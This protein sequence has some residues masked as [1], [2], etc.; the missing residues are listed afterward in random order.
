M[1]TNFKHAVLW[2]DFQ[3]LYTWSTNNMGST[4]NARYIYIN[5]FLLKIYINVLAL[6]LIIMH[7]H[8]KK[9]LHGDLI[10]Y[11]HAVVI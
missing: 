1:W 11:D 3:D 9:K 7:I 5:F 10:I 4:Y 8:Y 2:I 6:N